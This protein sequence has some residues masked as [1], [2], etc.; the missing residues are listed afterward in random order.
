MSNPAQAIILAAGYGSRLRPITDAA[1]KCLTEVNGYPILRH[2][3]AA[4]ELCGI[5]RVTI[6]VGYA[7]QV[8]VDAIGES[9]GKMAI[10]YRWNHDYATTNSMYSLWLARDVLEGG[11]LLL[12]GDVMIGRTTIHEAISGPTHEG[13]SLWVVDHFGPD[14]DGS[15]STADETGRIVKIEIVRTKLSKYSSSFFKSAGILKLQPEYGAR[16]A[17]WLEEE[18]QAG[19][20]NVYYD[21][22]LAKHLAEM[23]LFVSDIHT[24][25]WFE[26]DTVEDL[27]QA[28]RLFARRK[29]VVLVMEGAADLPIARLDGCTPLAVARTPHLDQIARVGRTGLLTTMYQGLPQDGVTSNLGILGFD[30]RRYYPYGLASFEA[31]AQDVFLDDSDVIFRCNLISL[32][33]QDRIRSYTAD[34]IPTATAAHIID[35]FDALDDDLELY[36]GQGYRHCLILRNAGFSAREIQAAPPHQNLGRRIDELWLTSASPAASGAVERLNALMK[37]SRER[38]RGSKHVHGSA[39][40]MLWLWSPSVAPRIPGF[41]ERHRIQGAMVAGLD[42]MRGMGVA[43]GMQTKEIVGANGELATNYRAKL[44][45]AKNYL[46]HNDLVTI[47]VNAPDEESHAGRVE[48]KIEALERID[49]ELVGPLLDFLERRYPGRYRIAVMPSHYTSVEN[50]RHL[51]LP[52]PFAVAGQ[53]IEPDGTTRF[54]ET[55][56]G[57]LS[58]SPLLSTRFLARFIEEEDGFLS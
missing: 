7:G 30:P 1:P 34:Q 9:F 50:S 49:R 18:V 35:G 54:G 48:G 14:S 37:S 42:V 4:L 6:V 55:F 38:L 27:R 21:L 25:P 29:H 26:I 15:M 12:E 41:S 36:C 40:D 58:P 33:E 13:R 52:V 19:N 57:E 10:E 5:E 28:E 43:L 11:A 16:F 3:L 24:R 31:L 32:D 8:V 39:A 44:K 51:E 22:V 23:P 56:A 47:H 45:Y 17:S 46:A 2:Q 53:G 20:T